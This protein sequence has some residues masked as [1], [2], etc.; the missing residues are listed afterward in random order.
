MN[1]KMLKEPIIWDGED[2]LKDLVIHLA[3]V[4]LFGVNFMFRFKIHS[5]VLFGVNFIFRLK[6]HNHLSIGK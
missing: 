4:F 2:I 3:F 1:L 5:R 6:I